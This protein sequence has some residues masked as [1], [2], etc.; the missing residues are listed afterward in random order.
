MSSGA[1][2][3]IPSSIT[4]GSRIQKLIRGIYREHEDHISLLP[5]FFQNKESR[6]KMKD[7]TSNRRNVISTLEMCPSAVVGYKNVEVNKRHSRLQYRVEMTGKKLGSCSG[8]L[9]LKTKIA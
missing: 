1:M 4:T 3:Y 2:I 5:F 9:W 6:L 7:K 8:S